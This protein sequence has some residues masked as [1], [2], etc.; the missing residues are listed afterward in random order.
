VTVPTAGSDDR[1]N[2]NDA[3]WLQPYTDDRENHNSS[4]PDDREA[5]NDKTQSRHLADDRESCG[6]NAKQRPLPAKRSQ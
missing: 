1:E 6:E 3:G 2:H 4:Y 5:H